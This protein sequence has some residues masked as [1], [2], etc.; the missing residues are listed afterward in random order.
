VTDLYYAKVSHTE[1][2]LQIVLGDKTRPD[3][4]VNVVIGIEQFETILYETAAAKLAIG[5]R[6]AVSAT[7]RMPLIKNACRERTC[8]TC[9]TKFMDK[10]LSGNQQ[11]C[12]PECRPSTHRMGSRNKTC[13]SC[14]EPFEDKS[15]CN[16][17]KYCKPECRPALKAALEKQAKRVDKLRLEGGQLPVMRKP[18]PKP[19]PKPKI[20]A[21]RYPRCKWCG[22][23]N[24][25]PSQPYC[26]GKCTKDAEAY[27]TH[28][29]EG[30]DVP[31]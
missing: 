17:M 2:N 16:I 9:E 10:T 19:K 13:L 25:R 4:S 12:K 29:G 5:Q 8:P 31:S 20:R 21:T 14:R 11:Y 24:P 30:H 22:R 3:W 1:D 26:P 18:E 28:T 27:H 23:P 15:R 7:P 6:Q